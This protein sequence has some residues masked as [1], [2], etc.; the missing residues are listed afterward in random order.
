MFSSV[1]IRS[2]Q[3]KIDANPAKLKKLEVQLLEYQRLWFRY[4]EFGA[5]VLEFNHRSRLR[6]TLGSPALARPGGERSCLLA[7]S[8]VQSSTDRIIQLSRLPYGS[9]LR[10]LSQHRR[11]CA[12]FQPVCR[13]SGCWPGLAEELSTNLFPTQS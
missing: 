4:S 13:R 1:L 8:R 10:V 6:V 9:R 5:N 3:V 7:P 11:G 2:F 12:R